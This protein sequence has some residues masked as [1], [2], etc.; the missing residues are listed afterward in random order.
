[1]PEALRIFIAPP[2]EETLRTRLVGRGTDDARAARA[3]AG[4]REVRTGRAGRVRT[5][6]TNDRLDDAVEELE[7]IVKRAAL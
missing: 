7:R 4:D 2:S 3:P 6:V 5:V 1:M